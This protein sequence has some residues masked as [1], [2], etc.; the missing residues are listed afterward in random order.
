MAALRHSPRER[1]SAGAHQ[2]RGDSAC[3]MEDVEHLSDRQFHLVHE[4]VTLLLTRDEHERI[5][6]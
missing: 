6:E 2:G 4:L 1:F 3:A 5:D